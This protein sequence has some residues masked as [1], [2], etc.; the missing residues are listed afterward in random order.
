VDK[1]NIKMIIFGLIL[2]VVLFPITVNVL[3][4]LPFFIT[5]I[6]L[7][8]NDWLSFWGSYGG[9]VIGGLGALI[10]VYYTIHYYKEK[11]NVQQ[12]IVIITP[13]L[14]RLKFLQKKI[15]DREVIKDEDLFRISVDKEIRNKIKS[16]N[17][18]VAYLKGFFAEQA[19][20]TLIGVFQLT[21]EEGET[22]F[23]HSTLDY[24]RWPAEVREYA[25]IIAN[26]SL[27]RNCT[28]LLCND[29]KLAYMISVEESG[30][31]GMWPYWWH[32]EYLRDREDIK[33]LLKKL[34]DLV[35]ELTN[36]FESEYDKMYA[37]I[38]DRNYNN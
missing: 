30:S 38:Y 4:F 13:Q 29:P 3:M 18:K 35:D 6:D 7:K 23:Y 37:M 34:F 8:A 22:D 11:D 17:K 12:K 26:H 15:M 19:V 32:T 10:S 36:Y 2:I 21:N 33:K 27:Y 20:G 24:F 14:E 28:E 31:A 25:E 5:H 9:G 16:Y 1:V